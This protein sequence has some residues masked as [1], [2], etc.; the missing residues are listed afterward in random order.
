MSVGKYCVFRDFAMGFTGHIGSA[1][2]MFV[3]LGVVF[4]LE[5]MPELFLSD[6]GRN[7][8]TKPL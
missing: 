4:I 1:A 6:K 3:L 5:S 8:L 2:E 7:T